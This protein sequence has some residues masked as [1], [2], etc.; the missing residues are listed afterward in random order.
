MQE[1]IPA[2]P[3]ELKSLSK[4]HPYR[5]LWTASSRLLDYYG[6]LTY[7]PISA[8]ADRNKL[9]HFFTDRG[10][11]LPDTVIGSR[12]AEL[13]E[14]A[15]AATESFTEPIVEIG[16]YRGA[17]TRQLALATKRLVYAVD[18]YVG[19]GGWESDMAMFKEKT[20]SLSNVCHLKETSGSAFKQLQDHLFSF[21]FVDAVNDFYN[22]WFNFSAWA[23]LVRPG[24]LIAVDSVDDWPG[25]NLACHKI[26]A[27]TDKYS[28]WGYCPDLAI[29]QKKA[30]S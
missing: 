21:V 25:P 10:S 3:F 28:L 18:P 22:T 6:R 12:K 14:L 1:T 9:V 30:T 29:V 27:Q 8:Q 2:D 24:G 19:Y 5:L 4:I 13:L 26:L 23:S 16:S 20:H 7:K 17:T 15:V 11:P